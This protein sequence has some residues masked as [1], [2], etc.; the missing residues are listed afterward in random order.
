MGK[1]PTPVGY[2]TKKMGE[3]IGVKIPVN[4]KRWSCPHCGKVNKKRVLDRVAYGFHG[5]Q[6][7]PKRGVR[8]RGMTLTEL[9]DPDNDEADKISVHFARLRANL[10]K[11]GYRPQYFRVTEFRPREG[12]TSENPKQYRH[13]H[14]LM[15]AYIPQAVISNA[16]YEATNHTAYVVWVNASDI[17]KG[18]GYLSKYLTKSMNDEHF[19]KHERRFSFSQKC[20]PLVAFEEWR[21][22]DGVLIGK[23]PNRVDGE[24]FKRPIKGEWEFTYDPGWW[25]KSPEAIENKAYAIEKIESLKR[26]VEFMEKN[27][28]NGV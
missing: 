17:M 18:A 22:L 24:K 3:D 12:D 16:W 26:L 25:L 9:K 5:F 28:P 7:Q 14:V 27:Y 6:W 11:K 1:C 21:D 10:A 13:Y 8:I 2:A 23:I 15:N 4:C 20:F 19:G